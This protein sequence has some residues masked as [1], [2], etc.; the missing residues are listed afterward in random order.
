[1][2]KTRLLLI[3]RQQFTLKRRGVGASKLSC[4]HE[5]RGQLGSGRYRRFDFS[6]RSVLS[7]II[8]DMKEARR[9]GTLILPEMD[10]FRARARCEL[11]PHVRMASLQRVLLSANA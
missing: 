3:A 1:M 5:R 6:P 11:R 4:R 8:E 10:A 9:E 7:S 2:S